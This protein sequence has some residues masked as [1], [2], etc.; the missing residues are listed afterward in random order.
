MSIPST[1][2]AIKSEFE[3]PPARSI[4]ILTHFPKRN[5][6]RS[7]TSRRHPRARINLQQMTGGA[8]GVA[9]A[10]LCCGEIKQ[11]ITGARLFDAAHNTPYDTQRAFDTPFFLPISSSPAHGGLLSAPCQPATHKKAA[12]AH[13]HS[14]RHPHTAFYTYLWA[15]AQYQKL[16][17][18]AAVAT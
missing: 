16:R 4:S 5:L 9:L 13:I 18:A 14:T 2:R 1:W 10:C 12:G 3:I 15:G 8:G 17:N 11:K 6:A 7:L